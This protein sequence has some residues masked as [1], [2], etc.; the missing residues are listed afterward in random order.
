MLQPNV[1][2]RH[3]SPVSPG[4]ASLARLPL[5]RPAPNRQKFEFTADSENQGGALILFGGG[6]YRIEGSLSQG[7]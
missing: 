3:V 5:Y 7:L 2:S 6:V 1:V 4:N